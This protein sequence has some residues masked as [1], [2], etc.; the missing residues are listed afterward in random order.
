MIEYI[1]QSIVVE[2]DGTVPVINTVPGA[3][4]NQLNIQAEIHVSYFNIHN[5]C[6][7]IS[8]FGGVSG[9]T[10]KQTHTQTDS[11]TSYFI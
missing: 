5:G 4:S 3:S 9:E 1:F 11:L 7:T 10:N 2:R 6:A 8:R